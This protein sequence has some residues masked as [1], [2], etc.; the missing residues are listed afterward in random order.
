MASAKSSFLI[1]YSC[2]G[3]V[4]SIYFY[5]SSL[6]I[7]LFAK[8]IYMSLSN[9]FFNPFFICK[10]LF[11]IY[12]FKCILDEELAYQ[13]LDKDKISRPS[14]L[15]GRN[16]VEG[17]LSS[18]VYSVPIFRFESNFLTIT[19]Q[20]LFKKQLLLSYH[21]TPALLL[22]LGTCLSFLLDIICLIFFSIMEIH[23]FS[24]PT[25]ADDTCASK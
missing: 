11:N 22:P 9:D 24:R 13:V 6:S 19:E 7:V 2:K 18:L 15:A 21:S 5:Q 23:F 25:W 12:F 20:L 4:T 10:S 8:T 1:G 16:S 14:S 17:N 3:N